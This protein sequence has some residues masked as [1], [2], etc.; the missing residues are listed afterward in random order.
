[1]QCHVVLPP[2]LATI[3]IVLSPHY[4]LW[5]F[6]TL[7][8]GLALFFAPHNAS[9]ESRD[10]GGGNN[11][12]GDKLTESAVANRFGFQGQVHDQRVG[13]VNM[14]ARSY[15]LDGYSTVLPNGGAGKATNG[16]GEKVYGVH[17]TSRKGSEGM[18]L[19]GS[20]KASDNN[21][22]WFEKASS[23]GQFAILKSGGKGTGAGKNQ[24]AIIFDATDLPHTPGAGGFRARGAIPL[25]GLNGRGITWYHNSGVQQHVNRILRYIAEGRTTYE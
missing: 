12:Q 17:W 7:A 19:T 11:G 14:R 20:I 10:G 16:G 2:K 25:S 1:M 4:L 6:A 24:V 22:T 9:A 21:L 5:R 18:D 3:R 15:K 8:L 13:L 23:P